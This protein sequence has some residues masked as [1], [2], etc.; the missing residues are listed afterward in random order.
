MWQGGSE[1]VPVGAKRVMLG[2][3]GGVSS[4]ENGVGPSLQEE[5]VR[6]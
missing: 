3:P 5:N 1:L 2:D 4:L 6:E